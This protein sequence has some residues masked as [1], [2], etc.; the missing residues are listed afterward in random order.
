MGKAYNSAKPGLHLWCVDLACDC[1]D[2]PRFRQ[3]RHR[4]PFLSI[5]PSSPPTN[6]QHLPLNTCL[7]RVSAR[8]ATR[9]IARSFA[10]QPAPHAMSSL[11][12]TRDWLKTVLRPYP[13]RDH[14]L[15]EVMG[16]LQSVRSL[17]VKTDAFSE[18]QFML[19]DQ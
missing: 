4:I 10:R 19:G 18:Y 7:S 17:A 11:D 2:A 14:V 12:L 1:D 3:R 15:E 13:S 16:I 8:L 6:S 9:L 5:H